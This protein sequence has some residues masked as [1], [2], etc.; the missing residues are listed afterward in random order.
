MGCGKFAYIGAPI[1]GVLLVKGVVVSLLVAALRHT[2]KKE[3]L[4]AEAGLKRSGPAE[5]AGPGP[6][7]LTKKV[8]VE[9]RG[10]IEGTPGLA[11]IVTT[12]PSGTQVSTI[13]TAASGVAIVSTLSAGIPGTVSVEPGKKAIVT[14]EHPV[15]LPEQTVV[16]GV[17]R[18]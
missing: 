9:N 6:G 18:L 2:E 8:V 7:K 14:A 13:P 10:S 17:V 3:R 1:I 5:T 4:R 11:E 16:T 12:G 15:G